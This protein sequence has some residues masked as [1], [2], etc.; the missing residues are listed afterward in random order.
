MDFFFFFVKGL[1]SSS[2]QNLSFFPFSSSATSTGMGYFLGLE[3]HAAAS[4]LRRFPSFFL[5]PRPLL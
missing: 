1:D 5:P 4:G 2:S 3:T